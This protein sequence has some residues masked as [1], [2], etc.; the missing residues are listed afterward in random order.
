MLCFYTKY[1]QFC[2]ESASYECFHFQEETVSSAWFC[3]WCLQNPSKVLGRGP[4]GI[5]FS[6]VLFRLR[7]LSLIYA[8]DYLS[9]C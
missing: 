3:Y 6:R 8:H 5:F 4:A 7:S 2:V 1:I 9:V